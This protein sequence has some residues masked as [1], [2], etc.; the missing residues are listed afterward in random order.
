MAD[1]N[2][3]KFKN[4]RDFLSYMNQNTQNPLSQFVRIENGPPIRIIFA[5]GSDVIQRNL[6]WFDDWARNRR[7]L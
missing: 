2:N 4:V 7:D 5:I 1:I 3:P 6:Q